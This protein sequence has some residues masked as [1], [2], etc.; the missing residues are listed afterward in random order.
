MLRC[1]EGS[2][3]RATCISTEVRKIRGANL[4]PCFTHCTCTHFL[5]SV[6]QAF[7]ETYAVWIPSSTP[8][9][10]MANLLRTVDPWV[11]TSLANQ[12]TVWHASDD[13]R[14]NIETRFP[15]FP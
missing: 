7:V 10:S 4:N 3:T 9:Y 2:A 14:G 13:S 12:L 15:Y 5:G 8:C 1:W 11:G 6:I